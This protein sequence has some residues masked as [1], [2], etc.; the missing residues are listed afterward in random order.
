MALEEPVY[1]IPPHIMRYSP[2]MDPNDKFLKFKWIGNEMLRVI[3][4]DGMEKLVDI[5]TDFQQ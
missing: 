2:K 5:G 1:R 3:N 4:D